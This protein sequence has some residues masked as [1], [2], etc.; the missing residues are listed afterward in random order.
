MCVPLDAI[1]TSRIGKGLELKSLTKMS[2][3]LQNSIPILLVCIGLSFLVGGLFIV[4]LKHKARLVIWLFI[5]KFWA[6]LIV[7]S[8][9]SGLE[10]KNHPKAISLVFC[11][12]FGLA[13][14]LLAVLTMCHLRRIRLVIAIMKTCSIFITDNLCSLLLP[15]VDL[16]LSMGVIVIWVTSSVYL[17]SLGYLD[18]QPQTLPFGAFHHSYG[19]WFLMVFHIFGT[20]WL[21]TTLLGCL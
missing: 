10:Y 17:Y 15:I 7:I 14:L 16:V 2:R 19:I 12:F 13:A 4:A 6:L 21:L 8:T 1:F 11:I 18:H 5:F 9:V 20:F 3:D